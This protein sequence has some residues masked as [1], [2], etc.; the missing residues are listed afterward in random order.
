MSELAADEVHFIV[1]GGIAAAAWGSIRLTS[2]LD[3][4]CEDSKAN[5]EALARCLTRLQAKISGSPSPPRRIEPGLLEGWQTAATF[6]TAHGQLDLLYNARGTTYAAI[7]GSALDVEI[8][9]IRVAICDIDSLIRMKIDA[10]RPRDL[11]VVAELEALRDLG[12]SMNSP[13]EI[14]QTNQL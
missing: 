1:I 11:E 8:D 2:D 10:G 12:V 7:A 3:I 13:P 5:R 9:G 14:E 6:E 4:L